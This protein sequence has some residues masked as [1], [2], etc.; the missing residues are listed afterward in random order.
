MKIIN[1]LKKN[2]TSLIILLLATLLILPKWILSVIFFDENITLRIINDVSDAAYLPIINSFSD[3]NLSNSYDN[4]LH[5]LKLISYPV[6][7][8]AINSFFFKLLGSY[9]FLFLE[10][11]CTAVFLWIFYNILL[12]F[13]FS[14][15]SSLA[16][17]V[18]FFILPTVL[19]DL[20]SL[21]IESLRLLSLNFESFYSTRFPRPIISNLFFFSYIFFI[22]KFYKDDIKSIK[23]TFI[24]TILIGLTSNLFFYLFFI[25]F[26][27]LIIV[28]SIKFKTKLLGFLFNNFKH[29]LYCSLLLLLLLGVFQIQIFFSEPDYIKRMGVF[30]INT[31]QKK[32]LFEYLYNFIFGIEFLFLFL[33]NTVFLFLSKN[34]LLKIFYYLFISSII[35]PIFFFTFLDKGVDYYH[36]FNWIVITGFLFPF[37]SILYF[38]DRKFLKYFKRFQYKNLIFLGI[39]GFLFYFN[40]NNFVNFKTLATNE[41]LKRYELNETTNFISQNHLFDNKKIKILNINY[42]LS[43]WFL[44]SDY[45]NF[46]IIPVSFWTPKTDLMLEEELI[47]SMKFLGLSNDNFY[48]LIKNKKKS[49]RFKNEFTFNYFGRKY[50][51]NSLV[52]FNN[53]ISDYT[54]IEQ[55][56]ILS[57]NLLNSHQVI[58]PKSEIN[59]LL[60]KFKKQNK[61]INPDIVI[62][63]N[64]INKF[65]NNNFCLIFKNNSFLIYSNRKLN[66]ECL[67]VKN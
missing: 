13:N 64:K 48:S 11:V 4:N 20:A 17:P 6:I 31:Y 47:S 67:L 61:I 16:L 52:T 8:L 51:A 56:F 5:N 25:E 46:S 53:D 43:I 9:S 55:S 38:L 60:N 12:E 65:D 35:S 39:F 57:N 62:L 42:K 34:K 44:L 50:L 23:N 3:L 63:N 58:I 37:M 26:F 10:V 19:R 15:L 30:S 14:Y 22:I 2:E 40:L 21:D 18:F 49:W 66:P 54:K 28:F 36:F 41:H 33:L 29:F 24:I 1:Y 59:R 27:L 32:I 45:N 7:S